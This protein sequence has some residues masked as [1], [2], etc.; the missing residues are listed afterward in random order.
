MSGS[1]KSHFLCLPIVNSALNIS[2]CPNLAFSDTNLPQGFGCF[3][4]SDGEDVGCVA[5]N[6]VS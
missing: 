3:L 1:T 4:C 2:A 6:S 5:F